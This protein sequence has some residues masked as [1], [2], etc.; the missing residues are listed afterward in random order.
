MNGT[1]SEV[2]PRG[3]AVKASAPMATTP[4]KRT[5]TIKTR[6]IQRTR[7]K[8]SA[9]FKLFSAAARLVSSGVIL[10]LSDSEL[11]VREYVTPP[12][13]V[14]GRECGCITEALARFWRHVS[15]T[16]RRVSAG[17]S[18]FLPTVEV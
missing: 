16:I 12:V 18:V 17:F 1:T 5:A 3:G 11:T 15:E 10:P 8:K 6:L 13:Y 2:L 4:A 14:F 9:I 7:R